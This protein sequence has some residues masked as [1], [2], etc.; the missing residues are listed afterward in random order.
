MT[1]AFSG[2][3]ERLFARLVAAIGPKLRTFLMRLGVESCDV[4]DVE[5]ETWVRIA[6]RR[7]SYLGRGPLADWVF[8]IARNEAINHVRK[9]DRRREVLAPDLQLDA[10][11]GTCLGEETAVALES[12]YERR[13]YWL[14]TA[15][16][17]LPPRQGETVRRH[18]L[19][20]EPFG[21][22]A[23]AHGTTAGTARKTN[24]D[25]MKSLR[26]RAPRELLD[27]SAD[28]TADYANSTEMRL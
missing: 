15:L 10:E 23:A 20:E 12:L 13:L 27:D 24:S 22:I 14:R 3:D 4:E 2:G 5:Q 28:W 9:R 1:Q 26:C 16:A 11:P 18:W 21:V 19:A 17:G 7:G 25:A 6:A 8:T